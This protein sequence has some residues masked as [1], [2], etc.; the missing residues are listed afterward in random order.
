MI[1]V[2]WSIGSLFVA[3]ILLWSLKTD[4]ASCQED[5]LGLSWTLLSLITLTTLLSCFV[6]SWL[7]IENYQR[8]RMA[9]LATWRITL[10]RC[11]VATRT[12]K[13]K[14]I[15]TLT[16]LVDSISIFTGLFAMPVLA[17]SVKDRCD[18][19]YETFTICLMLYSLFGVI[20]LAVL[21]CHFMYGKR[22]WGWVKRLPCCSCLSVVEYEQRVEFDIFDARDY[23]VK[24]NANIES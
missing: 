20:R 21:I 7:C 22:F 5:L 1:Y 2:L 14:T 4:S 8:R 19:E 3:S 24:V 15:F 17:K 16:I 11:V 23:V 10:H 9:R 12:A 6:G 18:L 13:S